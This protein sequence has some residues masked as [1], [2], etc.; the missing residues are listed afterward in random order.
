MGVFDESGAI[1]VV[2]GHRGVR[3]PG[4]MENTSDAFDLAAHDGARWV[5][6]DARRS[7]DGEAVVYHNGCTPDGAALINQTAAEL[8]S[9]HGIATLADVLARMPAEIGINVEVKNLPGEPD[10]DPND[11][12]VETVCAVLDRWAGAVPVL[13]SSFNPLTVAACRRLRP[14]S[15]AGLIHYNTLS[16]ADALPIAQEY[17][18]TALAS[19][20]GSPGL[21]ADG[22]AA[23][24]EAGFDLM[25]WTVNEVEVAR[26][27]ADAGV[28]AIC[29]DDP[30][31]VLAGLGARP[32]A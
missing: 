28:D 14:Q 17:G 32:P 8:S 26:Q 19:R 23:V 25:V 2:V 6:L 30:A 16:V 10:Y 22:V 1:P 15:P 9:V 3:R 24:H 20:V 12:I 7:A 31:A 18:A 21:D 13:L 11:E 4:V 27:L 5:E 29:T